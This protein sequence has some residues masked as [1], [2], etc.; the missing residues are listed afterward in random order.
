MIKTKQ[1]KKIVKQRTKKKIRQR[2]EPGP[3]L[4]KRSPAWPLLHA[5]KDKESNI[6]N[7]YLE[8]WKPG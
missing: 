4:N 8:L 1:D 7:I 6:F 3:L 2:V 5:A